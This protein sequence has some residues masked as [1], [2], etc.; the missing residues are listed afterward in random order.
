[1]VQPMPLYLKTPPSL[2]SFKSRLVL[3]FWYRLNQVV[4]EKRTSNRSSIL[5][6]FLLSD[7][8]TISSTRN[9][10]ERH[11]TAQQQEMYA[12]N[13]IKKG[14][15]RLIHKT[16]KHQSDLVPPAKDHEQ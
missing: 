5:R 7:R 9:L 10:E 1:M 12:Y 3:P 6:Q 13:D 8:F 14:K 2:A 15:E 16:T 4:L 11:H